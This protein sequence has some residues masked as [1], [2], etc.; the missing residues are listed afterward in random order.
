M[1]ATGVNNN[2]DN[3]NVQQYIPIS[4][5]IWSTARGHHG[6][7]SSRHLY[8]VLCVCHASSGYVV[9]GLSAMAAIMSYVYTTQNRIPIGA[10]FVPIYL[11]YVYRTKCMAIIRSGAH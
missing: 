1:L 2:N 5:C 10:E 4:Q 9:N 6:A 8:Y 7:M 11:D 3:P